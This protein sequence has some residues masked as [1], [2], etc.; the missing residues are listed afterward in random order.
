VNT[1][2][3]YAGIKAI[4]PDNVFELK[5]FPFAVAAIAAAL[6]V[7]AF[8]AQRRRWRIV[9]S[10]L[11]WSLPIGFLIDLQYWLYNYGHDL[12]PQAPCA[13]PFTPKVIGTTK[14]VTSTAKRW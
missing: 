9:V 7:G 13:S 14:V 3:H 6:V 10:F 12:E 4:D 11:A 2:N 5:L 8:R 1:L